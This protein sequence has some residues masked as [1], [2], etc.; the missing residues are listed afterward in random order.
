MGFAPI[1]WT[2]TAFFWPRQ[3]TDRAILAIRQTQEKKENGKACYFLALSST[4][5]FDIGSMES[6]RK[7][8]ILLLS[9]LVYVLLWHWLHGKHGSM[10]SM[11]KRQILLLSCLVYVLL[12]HWLHGKHEKKA[13]PATF[14]P[15]LRSPLTLAPWKAWEKGKSCYFLALS[16][17]FFNISS[18]ESVRKR[19]ILLLFLPCLRSSLTLAPWKA[20]EK[21]KPCYFLALSTF[22]FWHWLHGKHDTKA[23]PATFLPCLGSP[24]T[25]APWKAWEKGKACYFLALS[26]FSFNIG[27]MESMRKRQILLL[28]CLVYVLLGHWLHGKHEKKAHSATFLPCLRSL[29]TL[30]PWKAWEK[31]K[32]CYFLALSTFFFKIGSMESM[33]KRQI[34]LLSCLVY[35]LLWQESM[36]KRQILLLFLPV[37]VLL[38]H[39]LHGKH[40]KKANPATFLPCLRSP[41]TL[42]PWKAWEKGKACYFLAFSTFSFNIGSMESMRKRQILL[43]LPCLRSPLTTYNES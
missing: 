14:L 33:R 36:R 31:S 21:G 4:F 6:M 1:K 16:T 22:S 34:L 12:W 30:A 13:N 15:C 20:W 2:C 11:R 18:M 17:F 8:Q 40:E 35:V 42:A 3:L 7:R 26:T 43:L 5:S 37:Y 23:N 32:S 10:E 29:L 27:S 25:L 9:C 39:W 24:L 38:W 19:Q 41:L 28:S